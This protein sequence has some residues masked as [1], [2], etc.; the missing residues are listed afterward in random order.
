MYHS[1]DQISEPAKNV[2]PSTIDKY[3]AQRIIS[4]NFAAITPTKTAEPIIMENL[5]NFRS[6]FPSVIFAITNP[7]HNAA[8][9]NIH[10]FQ[11][12]D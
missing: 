12:S 5:I 6:I 10:T 4:L 11:F 1:N 3:T 2:I 9:T 7:V 8:M